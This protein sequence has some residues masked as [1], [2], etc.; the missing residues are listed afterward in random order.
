MTLTVVPL[1]QLLLRGDE[2][3][4]VCK[5]KSVNKVGEFRYIRLFAN[6]IVMHDELDARAKRDVVAQLFN[7]VVT[8]W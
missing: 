1:L 2:V 3:K 7:F 5:T 6:M 8:N 4:N